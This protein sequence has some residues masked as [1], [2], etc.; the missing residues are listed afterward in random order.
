MRILNSGNVGI[1]TSTPSSL[2][3]IVSG[4][5]TYMTI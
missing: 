2:L 4:S 5:N 1:G 3:N